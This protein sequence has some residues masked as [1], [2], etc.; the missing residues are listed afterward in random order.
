MTSVWWAASS[1][2]SWRFV[3]TMKTR[4]QL[5]LPSA[6]W[7][8]CRLAGVRLC[9]SGRWV[10]VQSVCPSCS[11]A[12]C[13]SGLKPQQWLSFTG[14]SRSWRLQSS[15]GT[16]I[17]NSAPNVHVEVNLHKKHVTAQHRFY[18]FLIKDEIICRTSVVSFW[19]AQRTKHLTLNVQVKCEVL[20]NF[21]ESHHELTHT[22]CFLHSFYQQPAFIS[23]CATW[24]IRHVLY[25]LESDGTNISDS[26]LITSWSSRDPQRSSSVQPPAINTRH[27]RA[28]APR[29]ELQ[30]DRWRQVSARPHKR[31]AVLLCRKNS[32]CDSLRL[33]RV[34]LNV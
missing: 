3:W 23:K 4:S 25:L 12:D 22:Q 33:Q 20:V 27:Q 18:A 19:A 6:R 8:S 5:L 26:A 31:R 7:A 30:V 28:A 15:S 21:T 16:F 24:N 2:G 14:S 9:V 32:C 10:C 13:D 17:A 34:L 11:S 29:S 1:A